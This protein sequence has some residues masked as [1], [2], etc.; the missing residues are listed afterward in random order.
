MH[1]RRKVGIG[2]CFIFMPA[3]A[4]LWAIAFDVQVQTMIRVL[5]LLFVPSLIIALGGKSIEHDEQ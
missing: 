2:M 4:P 5:T 1:W 3:V